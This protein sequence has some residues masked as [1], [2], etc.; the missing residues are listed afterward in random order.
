MND[1]KI[2]TLSGKPGQKPGHSIRIETDRSLDKDQWQL[3][4]FQGAI[5]FDSKNQVDQARLASLEARYK[6]L[7]ST[8]EAVVEE[9]LNLKSEAKTAVLRMR[10]AVEE[11]RYSLRSK[12]LKRRVECVA[13]HLNKFV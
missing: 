6:E 9:Y 4:D 13:E 8:H 7:I 2:I 10:V 1:L 5:L 3:K 12:D 11:C